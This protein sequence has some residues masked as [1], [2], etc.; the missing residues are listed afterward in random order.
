MKLPVVYANNCANDWG[1]REGILKALQQE[2]AS[3][4]LFFS[5]LYEMAPPLT[6]Y[7]CTL[8]LRQKLSVEGVRVL[9]GP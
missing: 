5:V 6:N 4:R 9:A 8:R 7:A 3:F 2:S 1:N